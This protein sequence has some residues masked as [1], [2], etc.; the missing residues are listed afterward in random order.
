MFESDTRLLAERPEQLAL[1]GLIIVRWSRAEQAMAF[2]Y[3]YLLAQREEPKEFGW[4]VDGLGVASFAAVRPLR[5]KLELLQLAIQ[6]RLGEGVLDQFK[7]SVMK[8]LESA[9]RERNVLAHG[10]VEAAEGRM[11]ALAVEWNG[12]DVCYDSAKLSHVLEKIGEAHEA[13][14]QFHNVLARQI[15]QT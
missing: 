3:D 11:D 7:A 14:S 15:L 1:I 9:G 10:L 2:F 4:P 5:T 13:L 8:K 12:N 6:W